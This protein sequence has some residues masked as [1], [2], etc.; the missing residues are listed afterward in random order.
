MTDK[1]VEVDRVVAKAVRKAKRRDKSVLGVWKVLMPY[2]RILIACS[3]KETSKPEKVA[4]ALNAMFCTY[5]ANELE[6]LQLFRPKHLE[7]PLVEDE[8]G[9]TDVVLPYPRVDLNAMLD[10]LVKIRADTLNQISQIKPQMVKT[11]R[12]M[13]WQSLFL[14]TSTGS[15]QREGEV[16]A[17]HAQLQ[18]MKFA[19]D[20][21]LNLTDRLVPEKLER[22][23]VFYAPM[24]VIRFTESGHETAGHVLVDLTTQKVD[25]A[26]TN[27]CDQN[28]DYAFGLEQAL[29][30]IR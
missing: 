1:P 18:A 5:A 21:C 29:G 2:H 25:E 19:I 6:L 14:P 15:L 3:D 9:H 4:T 30:P 28:H 22:H 16:S 23:D 11:Y 8:P 13:Q 12:R 7:R 10:K 24:A 17:K 26:F 20:M 27:L